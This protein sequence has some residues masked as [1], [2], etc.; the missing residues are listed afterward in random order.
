M[1]P[2]STVNIISDLCEVSDHLVL[3]RLEFMISPFL[4][5]NLSSTKG[6]ELAR[7]HSNSQKTGKFSQE[8]YIWEL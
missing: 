8:I 1:K 6:M 3:G 7:K 2:S 4:N 5:I